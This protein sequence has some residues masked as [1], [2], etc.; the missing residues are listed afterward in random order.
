MQE[1]KSLLVISMVS[2]KINGKKMKYIFK[3]HEKNERQKSQHKD[4]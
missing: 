2:Q 1:K 3:S 4:S